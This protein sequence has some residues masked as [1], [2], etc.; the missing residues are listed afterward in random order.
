MKKILVLVVVLCSTGTIYSQEVNLGAKAGINFATLK[1]GEHENFGGRTGFHLGLVAEMP[2]TSKFSV[3][4]E[5]L[6]SRQGA[7]GLD[8]DR[9]LKLDYVSVPLMLKYYLLSGFSLE[10]GPQVAFNIVG[11][12]DGHG[13]SREINDI[14]LLEFAA[15]LGT[16]YQFSSGLFFQAR[17]IHGITQAWDF[18]G[19]KN[20]NFQLSAGYKF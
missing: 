16:C 17:Y 15:G 6:Y 12:I 1:G 10:A 5:I 13:E 20:R 11:Q 9:T 7:T 3:Q 14:E 19:L 18:P 8:G 4:P 2:S